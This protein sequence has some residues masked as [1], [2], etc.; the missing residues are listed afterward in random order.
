[1]PLLS[2]P[3]EIKSLSDHLRA[4]REHVDSAFST[5]KAAGISTLAHDLR[6]IHDGLDGAISDLAEMQSALE[7]QPPMSGGADDE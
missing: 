1:M 6:Q 5:T 2:P 4:A 7:K 3:Q